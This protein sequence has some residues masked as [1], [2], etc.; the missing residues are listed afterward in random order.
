MI[1]FTSCNMLSFH[2]NSLFNNKMGF[3]CCKNKYEAL[4][5]KEDFTRCIQKML[6]ERF[7][8]VAFLFCVFF[9]MCLGVAAVIL[10]ILIII[11]KGKYYEVGVGY[12]FSNRSNT[13]IH[14][15]FRVLYFDES[16]WIGILM[17]ISEGIS[18]SLL[19]KLRLLNWLLDCDNG[20]FII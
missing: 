20:S 4:L 11:V 14:L 19:C 8:A 18:L 9:N 5:S 2:R 1:C 15:I 12:L 6:N 13:T 16:I 3:R 17:I 7:P 10:G